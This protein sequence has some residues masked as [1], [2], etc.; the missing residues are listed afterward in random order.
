MS[1]ACIWGT[2]Q[3][4]EAGGVAPSSR[5]REEGEGKFTEVA[6]EARRGE[7]TLGLWTQLT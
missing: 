7:A 6:V 5:G 1:W 3:R 4:Q 2:A